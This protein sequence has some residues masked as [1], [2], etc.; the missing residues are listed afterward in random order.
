MARSDTLLDPGDLLESF[1]NMCRESRAP[2]GDR[3]EDGWGAAWLNGGNNWSISKST[4]PIWEDDDGRRKV[5]ACRVLCLHARSASFPEHRENIEFNQ[6]FT[7]DR[8]AFVFNGLIR[9]V[10]LP[11]ALSGRIGSQKIWSLLQSL[12]KTLSP[13]E[14]LARL[15]QILE[16][17]SRDVQALNLGLCDGTHLSVFSRSS[18]NAEYYRT[19]LCRRPGLTL[20]SS[21]PLAK[22]PFTPL[23]FGQVHSL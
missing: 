12:M 21:E 5:P 17:K 2:D 7:H 15:N 4:R 19:H 9:G 22:L 11:R 23:A 10:S 14:A 6:P 8:L 16:K 18:R 13:P 1:S 3:Q 20:I